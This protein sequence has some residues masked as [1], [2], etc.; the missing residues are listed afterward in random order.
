[1]VKQGRPSQSYFK[2]VSVIRFCSRPIGVDIIADDFQIN[3]KTI[4]VATFIFLYILCSVTAVYQYI[5]EDW[6]V[7]LDVFSQVSCA[8]QGLVKFLSALLHAKLYR[9]LAVEIGEI[10]EKYQVISKKYEDKLWEWNKKMKQILFAI[11]VVYSGTAMVILMAPLVIYIFTGEQNPILL[12][13]LPFFDS[14][15]AHGFFINQAFNAICVVIAAFGLYAGDLYLLLFLT[16][17]MFFYDIFALKV[18]D[19]HEIMQHDE[20]DKRITN[21]VKDILEWHQYYLNFNDTCNL[22]FFWTISAH[23]ICTTMGILSTLLIIMLKYWPGAYV[24]I[25]VLFL[26]LYMY[27]ILGTRVELCNDRFCCGIYDINWYGLDV[28]N[29]K[30]IQLMLLKSQAPRDIMIAGVQ[31]LSV[32]TALTITRSIYSLV[33]M[34]LQFQRN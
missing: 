10:Y 11:A 32:N 7:L 6:S 31:P 9:K 26:W 5:A 22:M 33:M 21:L 27:C 1:M 25:I 18:K 29:Q 16:H 20:K 14:Y 34:V 15:A 19:L 4:V 13:E 30:M 8:T 17:S 12:T 3:A 23:I 2:T 28:R 24:Y